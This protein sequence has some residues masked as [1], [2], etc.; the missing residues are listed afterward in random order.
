M[1]KVLTVDH[2]PWKPLRPS[3]WIADASALER[4]STSVQGQFG[5]ALDFARNGALE[6][7]L[8]LG[9]VSEPAWVRSSVPMRRTPTTPM[10]SV[11]SNGCMSEAFLI[12][13]RERDVITRRAMPR[14]KA[15]GPPVVLCSIAPPTWDVNELKI[16]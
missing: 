8:S 11:G 12:A 1:K 5:S 6:G 3:D 15:K 2:L 9:L 14:S 4:Q 7:A 13:R 10:P 16:A